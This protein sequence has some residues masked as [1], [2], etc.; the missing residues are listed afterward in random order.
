MKIWRV[1]FLGL[2][3][4]S[5]MAGCSKDDWQN[6]EQSNLDLKADPVEGLVIP[7][8]Q[9]S[10]GDDTEAFKAAFAAAKLAGPGT[11]V[12]MEEGEYHLGFLEIYDF[13]GSFV[14]VGKDKTIITVMNHMD[15]Q[16]VLDRNLMP[17]LVK[18][19]GGDVFS[20]NFTL[21]TPAGTLT[22]T[23]LPAG[24]I[25]SLVAL[26]AGNAVYELNNED[27]SIKAVI[28]QVRFKG[29]E[30]E[31][32][33]GY[34]KGHNCNMGLRAGFDCR[35]G[36]NVPR[37]KI[38]VKVINSDFETFIY[39][40]TLEG[41]K[42][43]RLMVGDKNNGNTF[44]DNDQAG[45]M[46]ESRHME[47]RIEGNTLNIPAFS[48]GM[49]LDDYPWYDILKDEQE[50]EQTI[51]LVQNNVFNLVHS[52]YALYLNN[53]RHR[54]YPAE[55]PVI[56]QVKNNQ[57]NMTDGYEWALLSYYTT[58]V[59]IR[60]NQFRG[61]GDLAMFLVNY[62]ENGLVLGNNFSTAELNTGAV[63]LTKST[64]NWT[65]VGGNLG[66][67]VFN[68]GTN[69]VITGFNVSQSEFP[70]GQTIVDNMK[71]IKEAIKSLKGQWK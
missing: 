44:S 50:S 4:A 51:Y 71:E 42:N 1:F 22:D 14:G 52:E 30:L 23:G 33:P 15:G 39:A 3:Y 59:V 53:I 6:K 58:G 45:G 13:Y 47:I 8:G 38:D 46:W 40:L 18:F 37:A 57:F 27:R 24:N 12:L 34:N 67:K 20:S 28:D 26:T 54:W 35:T 62:S 2:L 5:L 49:D 10:G 60:N 29:H 9:P 7:V 65:I 25:K 63:Y 64:K 11:V 43:G 70:L 48:Y 41:T 61:H 31:G 66:E 36:S 16:A 32:G 55:V 69:N 19:V 68:A 17:D 21:Q 56:F